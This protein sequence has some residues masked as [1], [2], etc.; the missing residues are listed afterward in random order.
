[1]FK[2]KLKSKKVDEIR[3]EDIESIKSVLSG[4]QLGEL[5][6]SQQRFVVPLEGSSSIDDAIDDIIETRPRSK[7]MYTKYISYLHDFISSLGSNTHSYHID[8]K[9]GKIVSEWNDIIPK[10]PRAGESIRRKK[11]ISLSE[12][13]EYYKVMI[14]LMD[15]HEALSWAKLNRQYKDEDLKHIVSNYDAAAEK[16]E[17]ASRSFLSFFSKIY[18]SA[19]AFE[20]WQRSNK[21]PITKSDDQ[22]EPI[23]KSEDAANNRNVYIK[24]MST[25]AENLSQ[26]F[27]DHAQDNDPSR[28]QS[29]RTFSTLISNASESLIPRTIVF[30]R[31]PIDLARMSDFSKSGIASCHSPGSSQFGCALFD[32]NRNG[33]I[34]YVISNSDLEKYKDKLQDRDFFYDEDRKKDGAYPLLRLRIRRFYFKK[35]DSEFGV[36]ELKTYGGAIIPTFKDKVNEVCMG[37]QTN[38]INDVMSYARNYAL[39]T[40]EFVFVGGSYS[41][42]E[43]KVLLEKFLG[44]KVR[45]DNNAGDV[46]V[47]G[48]ESLPSLTTSGLHTFKQSIVYMYYGE[49]INTRYQR[50][51]DTNIKILSQ[52]EQ[53][54]KCEIETYVKIL[55]R[56]SYHEDNILGEFIAIKG[57]DH[58][59]T[60]QRIMSEWDLLGSKLEISK[61]DIYGIY[62]KISTPIE[63]PVP[64]TYTKAML[65]TI[66]EHFHSVE[67]MDAL[68]DE[69]DP[70]IDQ[71]FREFIAKYKKTTVQQTAQLEMINRKRRFLRNML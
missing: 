39:T 14:K 27:L 18:Y 34:A 54:A 29:Y 67:F 68:G 3:D 13:I 41:D 4:D 1:M 38:S 69:R 8:S 16:A 64:P 22:N 50:E 55:K 58:L 62:A 2:F 31:A 15:M 23:T 70:E 11:E 71:A 21:Y 35:T 5:F 43:P 30:S 46:H 51:V 28:G 6:G 20:G 56:P 49:D 60:A 42:D 10:G 32:S 44:V 26:I 36:P 63:I 53:S 57:I 47:A 66:R 61:V 59:E 25:F 7:K 52:T 17:E 24:V 12:F 33:A 37:K 48:N 65:K 45:S 9:T 40:R 19:G